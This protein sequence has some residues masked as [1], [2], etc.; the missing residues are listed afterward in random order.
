[1]IPNTLNTSIIS[2][3]NIIILLYSFVIN[4]KVY[5]SY[6]YVSLPFLFSLFFLFF[7]I[8]VHS[9]V[10]LSGT[11]D[12]YYKHSIDIRYITYAAVFITLL[13]LFFNIGVTLNLLIK[14]KGQIK[15][16]KY[17]RHLNYAIIFKTGIFLFI[18]GAAVKLTYFCV[19]GGGNIFTY[20]TTY[21]AIQLQQVSKTGGA[22]FQTYLN[23][24]FVTLDIGAD[25]LLIY[26]LKTGKHRK[27]ITS[28]ILI[29]LIL[30]FNSRFAL[31][32]LLIQILIILSLY[33]EK[34]RK[35]LPVISF[36][37][38]IPL[39]LMLVVGLG[40]YRDRTNNVQFSNVSYIYFLMGQFHPMLA[41]ADAME[42]EKDFGNKRWG[43]TI[44]LPIIQK[45]I[46][47]SIWKNKELNAA[48]I[49]TKIMSPGSLESGFA[50]APGIVFDSYLNFG[51]SGSMLFFMLLG[52]FVSKLQRF[53]YY[54][55]RKSNDNTL[56]A[57]LTAVL[58]SSLLS[59]RGADLSN[60]PIL[61]IYYFPIL[62]LVFC[63]I[64]IKI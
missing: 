17:I 30:W 3:I 64:K 15:N 6:C 48:A 37:I 39:I 55:F 52:V 14:Q 60:M 8:G 31:I 11:T 57:L 13:N 21:F 10:I 59:L 43:K 23:F 36:G 32:R 1:M 34:I 5:K 61:I 62:F 24:L 47:R 45:P 41:T 26:T 2:I 56:Y 58:A 50:V 20:A 38:F 25:L 33:K 4:K 29:S 42:F 53:L 40:V 18:I 22:T 63:K 49:Y 44:I 54:N 51:Y 46:P 12:L 16:F 35:K 19:L 7:T 9:F 28:C 27:L